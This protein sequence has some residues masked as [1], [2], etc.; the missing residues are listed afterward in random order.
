MPPGCINWGDYTHLDRGEWGGILPAMTSRPPPPP[1]RQPGA[2]ASPPPAAEEVLPRVYRIACPF[3]DGGIVHVYYLDAPEPALID[4]GV[5]RS[6]GEVIGPA[7]AGAGFALGDVRHIFNTHGHWDHMG[8]NEAVRAFATGA[9]TYVNAEDAYLLQD[10]ERHVHGYVSYPQRIL[11]D[12][13]G[14]EAMAVTLRRSIGTPTPVDVAVEDGATYRLGGG[15]RLRAIHTPGHSWGSTSY[16]MEVEGG[17]PTGANAGGA[18]FTGDGVQGLGSRPG[19]LPLVFDDSQAYRATL[20]KL[21][22]VAFQALCLGHSF[23][24]LSPASGRDPV[25]R[26]GAARTFLQESGE[27]AKAVEEAMRSVLNTEG[28]TGFLPTARATLGRLAEPL[29]LELDDGGLSARSLATLHAFYRELTGA[30]L[31]V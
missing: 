26:G 20:V 7:L 1:A 13:V 23:C 5:A 3:G 2:P 14:L 27:G 22:E 25:R 15:V 12:A 28:S 10:V 8:G 24:G 16:L 30:P 29:A 31:P 6:P 11:G 9:R 18:L 21:S 17:A 4:T 19:Q